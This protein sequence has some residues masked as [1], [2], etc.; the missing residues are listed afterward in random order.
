M[1]DQS[2]VIIWTYKKVQ[3]NDF[4]IQWA[5]TTTLKLTNDMVHGDSSIMSLSMAVL[6]PWKSASYGTDWDSC[7]AQGHDKKN[8]VL[9]NSHFVSSV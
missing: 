6:L 2:A 1:E 9:I 3:D 4:T 8:P 5:H 7:C